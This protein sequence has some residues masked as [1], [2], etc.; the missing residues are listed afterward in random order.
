MS[1]QTQADWPAEVRQRVFRHLEEIDK[2]LSAQNVEWMQRRAIVDD[3]EG[4]ITEMLTA[5]KVGVPTVGDIEAILVELDPPAS[6]A[7]GAGAS[8]SPVPQTLPVDLPPATLSRK[9]VLG[10]IFAPMLLILV[11]MLL[12]APAAQP[13]LLFP[14]FAGSAVAMIVP[15]LLLGIAGPFVTTI[16]GIVA[17]G[18]IRRSNGRIYGLPLAIADALFYPLIVLDVLMISFVVYPAVAV[19][20]GVVEHGLK[21]VA[22][23]D[24][25]N[26]G[27]PALMCL[28]GAVVCVVVDWL[29]A[30]MVWKAVRK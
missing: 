1:S 15:L 19:M 10:A 14:G 5:R 6:Y 29:L 13:R 4:Q 20:V 16:C 2:A 30:R 24:F 11:P 27:N 25:D 3:V 23:P 18:E 21:G 28:M 7:S 9:A 26:E 17:I 12:V 22:H 8:N